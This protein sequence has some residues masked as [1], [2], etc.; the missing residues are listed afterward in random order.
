MGESERQGAVGQMKRAT[1]N[2]TDGAPVL[3]GLP[4]HQ[5]SCVTNLGAGIAEN[6]SLS[7]TPTICYHGKLSVVHCIAVLSKHHINVKF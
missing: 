7:Q 2:E 5:R 6:V 3:G 4:L 1:R